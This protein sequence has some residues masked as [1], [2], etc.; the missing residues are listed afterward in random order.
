MSHLEQ[1]AAEATD[2]WETTEN[3][4][5]YLRI[6]IVSRNLHRREPKSAKVASLC[7]LRSFAVLFSPRVRIVKRKLAANHRQTRRCSHAGQNHTQSGIEQQVNEAT[8][9]EA[10]TGASSLCGH[11]LITAVR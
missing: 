6:L 9:S 1:E 11:R 4:L 10:K 5:E 3:S 7:A 2:R 8:E